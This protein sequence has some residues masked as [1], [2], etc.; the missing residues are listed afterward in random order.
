VEN[1]VLEVAVEALRSSVFMHVLTSPHGRLFVHAGCVGHHGVAILLPGYAGS[2]K[3]TLVAELVR[4]GALYYTDDYAPLDADGLVHP[5][6]LPLWM[7][8][9]QT[10][11]GRPRRAEDLGGAV[12]DQPLPVAV[13]AQTVFRKGGGWYV[14]PCSASEATLLVLKHALDPQR[15]PEFALPAVRR[16]VTGAL[17]LEGERGD[18]EAAA[19][20][21]L[22]LAEGRGQSLP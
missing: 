5:Y 22:E 6:P 4:A 15:Q 11:S 17:V 19:A 8:D 20:T 21:L 12:G 9:P 3:T 16:A 14:R 13:V 1:K 2:G 7:S 10:P 18:A